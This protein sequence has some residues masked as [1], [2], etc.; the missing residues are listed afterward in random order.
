MVS[1]VLKSPTKTTILIFYHFNSKLNSSHVASI[2]TERRK[3]S[4]QR[5]LLLSLFIQIFVLVDLDPLNMV[6]IY[7]QRAQA[8]LSNSFVTSNK[9]SLLHFLTIGKDSS[10]M[11]KQ[12]QMLKYLFFR[13][14]LL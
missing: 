6:R 10:R 7:L 8:S 2:L 3:F 4:I 12:R 5:W 11:E 9:I 13:H 1:L 14:S